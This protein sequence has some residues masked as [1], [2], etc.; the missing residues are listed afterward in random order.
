MHAIAYWLLPEASARERLAKI[1]S[2]LAARFD[3]PHFIP[4]VTLFVAPDDSCLAAKVVSRIPRIEITLTVTGISYSEKFTRTLFVRFAPSEPLQQ[5]SDTLAALTHARRSAIDPHLSLL[6]KH[7]TT[8]TK[9]ELA[10][11]LRLPF[12]HICFDS[13]CAMRCAS[14]TRNAADVGAWKLLASQNSKMR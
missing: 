11:S 3:A 7:A 2:A 4:H 13:V 8:L 14:P 12:D 10:A 6:Y 9:R 5:L 1:I